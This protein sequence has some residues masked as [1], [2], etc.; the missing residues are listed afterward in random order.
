MNKTVV[1]IFVVLAVLVLSLQSCTQQHNAKSSG[2]TELGKI[3]VTES[4][5]P[6]HPGSFWNVN[7]KRFIYAPAFDFNSVEG[8]NTYKFVLTDKSGKSVAFE[9]ASPKAPLSPVWKSLHVGRITVEVQALDKSGRVLATVGHRKFIKSIAFNGPYQQTCFDYTQSGRRCLEDVLHQAKVQYWL[10]TGQPD[11]NYDLYVYPSRIMGSIMAGA[12]CYSRLS[13]RPQ[14][15]NEAIQIARAAADFLLSLAAK[16]GSPTQYWTPTNWPGVPHDGHPCY[17]DQTLVYVPS[18]AAQAFLDLYDVTQDK[19]YFDAATRMADTYVR[20]QRPD[21]TW[22]QLIKIE[23]GEPAAPNLLIPTRVIQ[24]FD[25]LQN[26]YGLKQYNS[27]REAAFKWLL[28]N[29]VKTFN[30]QGQFEDIRAMPPYGNLSRQ[31]AAHAAILLLDRAGT[32]HGYIKIADELLRFAEDQFIVWDANDPVAGKNWI[33]PAALEQY[34]FYTP[35]SHSNHDMILAYLKAY[36]VTGQKMYQAKAVAL[37][38]TLV[39]AQQY[40]GGGEIPTHLRTQLPEPNWINC[41]IY[42]AITL[43]VSNNLLKQGM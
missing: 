26:Q 29:P 19:K 10:K 21:G 41:S 42:P 32:K 12:S 33:V 38:D 31:E 22:Y 23:T 27:A 39:I 14:D 13:P 20:L 43:I 40:Y 30:W 9:A 4:A 37:A 34:Q 25:R 16:P 11:P 15:A 24:F 5:E 2:L 8:A 28:E 17:D 7:A 1:L 35:I 18:D 3:A 6:I 36:E